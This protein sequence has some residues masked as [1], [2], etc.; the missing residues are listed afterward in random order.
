M[1]AMWRVQPKNTALL[2]I[3]MQNDFVPEGHPMEVPMARRRIP[4]MQ[5]VIT[6]CREAGIR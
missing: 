5:K 3:D 2:V 1:N 4:E 6:G